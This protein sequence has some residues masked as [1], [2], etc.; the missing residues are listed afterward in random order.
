MKRLIL[1]LSLLPLLLCGC[2]EK[3]LSRTV[4]CMDTVM[5]LNIWGGDEQTLTELQSLLTQLEATWSVTREDS[6][7]SRLTRGERAELG[8]EEAA[9]LQSAQELC[10]QTR[11]AF[12]PH[13]HALSQAWG[14]YG[15]QYRVP[16][17][18]E[19]A[20]ALQLQQWDLGGIL[21]G[22]AGLRC[23]QLLEKTSVSR[24]MLVL[25]GNVQTYGSKSDGSPWQIG[26]QNP[27]GGNPIG[28]IYVEGTR[29]VV[30]SGDYQRYFEEN[31]AHYHHILDA[32]TGYPADTGLRSVT[33]VCADG[34]RADALSTALFV[35]GLERGS[36]FWR[37]CN[38][39]EAVFLTSDGRVLATQ[40]LTLTG[41]DYEV[42]S[43]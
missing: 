10:A 31:G 7:P 20:R 34:A 3:Q 11:G 9:L 29:A 19:I 1:L 42:I 4:F 2:R 14:F 5:D 22:Y 41:C 15:G 35:M 30:T 26:I 36:D 18:E 38:D 28:I 40:G 37:S 16:S 27:D 23:V 8:A 43:R 32:A 24:A 17:S 21:K 39:F 33:I 6:V 25:G 13:L 12:N